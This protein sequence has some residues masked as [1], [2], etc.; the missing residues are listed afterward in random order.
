MYVAIYKRAKIT[1]N[2]TIIWGLVRINICKY[3]ASSY[4]YRY[5]TCIIA[6]ATTLSDYNRKNTRKY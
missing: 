6:Q 2:L 5:S 4:A 1:G 3:Y